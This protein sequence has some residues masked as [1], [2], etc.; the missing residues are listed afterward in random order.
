MK[1][2]A[3]IAAFTALA[4]PALAEITVTEA[5]ALLPYPGAPAAAIYFVLTNSD[6]PDDRLLSA[7]LEQARLVQLHQ[8]VETDGIMQMQ[9]QPD[10]FALPADSSLIFTD[11][12]R[13]VMLMGLTLPDTL[14]DTLTLV[15][16]F[17]QA[18]DIVLDV[19][20]ALR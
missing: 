13:H 8:T 18:G 15:L 17:E 20:L 19:P 16:S 4:A 1:N 10:G 9:H 5:R 11:G 12:G 3:T 2:L 6:G 14:P 7:A